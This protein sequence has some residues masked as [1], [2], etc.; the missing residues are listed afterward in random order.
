MLDRWSP[1]VLTLLI[2]VICAWFAVTPPAPTGEDISPREFSSARAMKDVRVIASKPHPTGSL[3]NA[4]VRAYL[5]ERLA[6]LGLEVSV[7]EAMLPDSMLQRLNG[8]SGQNVSEQAIFNIIGVLPGE[9]RAKPALLL[10]AHHDTVWA[11]PGAA[12]DTIGLASILEIIRA[13]KLLE[14]RERDIIV[15]FTDAEELGLAGAAHFFRENPL[16]DQIGVVI[17]FEARGGGG[18]ANMFQTSAENGALAQLYAREV[19]QPSA[20]SLST[21]VYNVLPNDT[22]LTPALEKDYVAYNIA[23][24][25]MAEHY[26]SPQIDADVL[27]ER[28]LQ[29]M[30][31]QGLDL[32]R[33]LVQAETLPAKKPDAV[34]FD[35]F[36]L[37]TI[38]YAPFW[39]R[40]FLTAGAVVYALSVKHSVQ[41]KEIVSGCARMVGVLVVGG[42]VLT[43]LNKLSGHSATANY[44]DRLAAIPKLEWMA[45]FVGMF[46]FF[47]FFGGKVL[48]VNGRLGAA[49]PLFGLALIGQALAPTAA[50]FIVLPVMMCGIASWALQRWKDK[51]VSLGIVGVLAIL[52]LAYMGFLGHLL[53]LGVGPDMLA[54]AILPTAIAILAILPFYPG[55][56]QRQS[57]GMALAGLGLAVGM[58][59]WIRLDPIAS[60]VPLY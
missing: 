41:S 13:V 59:L 10:M 44:Y 46:A 22:D 58:A 25:G 3:E 4:Q 52:A 11:S 47:S 24:I 42:V 57:G 37:F 56:S 43:A 35:L 33:A 53:M 1:L 18:T 20:S 32:T 8:W 28:T 26:H 34:F 40:V 15:L 60:T 12:D 50:Y 21:F 5:V 38:V 39:G 55:L 48:S 27:D 30:G 6:Q 49:I 31:S 51:R 14:R 29:H 45:L 19:G 2:S 23:N 36:G 7:S 17:N 9:D 16:R 54:V